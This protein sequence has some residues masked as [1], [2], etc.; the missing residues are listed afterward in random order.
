LK[1]TKTISYYFYLNGILTM[2]LLP[3]T[4]DFSVINI[5]YNH[6]LSSDIV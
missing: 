6:H 4:T 3:S 1:I 2:Q 5:F